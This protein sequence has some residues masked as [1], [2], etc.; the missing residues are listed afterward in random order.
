MTRPGIE[1]RSPGPLAN[2]LPT[3]PM[4]RV[5]GKIHFFSHTHPLTYIYYIYIYIYIY[6]HTHIC[7]YVEKGKIHFSYMYVVKGKIHFS[8]SL[9]HTHTNGTGK[10][11]QTKD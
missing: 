8:L 11:I 6:T 1:P 2:T 10:F 3:R 9:S 5:D 7:M 4:S